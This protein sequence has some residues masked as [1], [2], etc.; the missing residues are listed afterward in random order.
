MKKLDN[1]AKGFLA[2]SLAIT[3]LMAVLFSA[4]WHKGCDPAHPYHK[5]F[6]NLCLQKAR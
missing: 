6:A 4:T 3:G 1:T 5:V 2:F